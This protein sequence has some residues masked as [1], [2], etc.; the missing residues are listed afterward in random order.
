MGNEKKERLQDK[1]QVLTRF[2]EK[3]IAWIRQEAAHRR[4]T[5]VHL[6]RMALF[7]WLRREAQTDEP[8]VSNV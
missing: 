6:I 4:L 5:P 2:T 3:D 1:N 7:D 8:K